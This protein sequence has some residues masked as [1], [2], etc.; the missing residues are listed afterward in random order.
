[1]S[2]RASAPAWLALPANA[3]AGLGS[4]TSS[5]PMPPLPTT[6]VH[7]GQ[8]VTSNGAGVL[9]TILG[10]CVAVCLHD[11]QER[12]GG[13]NQ[14]L[15]PTVGAELDQPGRYGPTAIDELVRRMV[16][17]GANRERL[18]ATIVGGAS[19]LAAF[20]DAEHLGMRNV[21][22]ARAGLARHKIKIVGADVGGRRGRK[23]QFSPRDGQVHVQLIG[24]Q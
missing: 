2:R 14:F 1:V 13:I 3:A 20:D 5:L 16:R 9:S 17:D 19:V 10:S 11:A 23:L 24:A 8:L 18:T 7:P 12:I 22:T 4:A 21:A 15:W 6:Y